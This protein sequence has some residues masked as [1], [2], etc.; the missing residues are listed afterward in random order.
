MGNNMKI[1]AALAGA[2]FLLGGTAFFVTSSGNNVSATGKKKEI[3]ELPELS[4][5]I[6]EG[7]VRISGFVDEVTGK[8][9]IV[10][11]SNTGLAVLPRGNG[12]QFASNDSEHQNDGILVPI[13]PRKQDGESIEEFRKRMQEFFHGKRIPR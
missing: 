12:K 5:K 3:R 6:S 2:A 4:A 13:D 9:Y 1:L 10:V 11:Q 8:E 7:N